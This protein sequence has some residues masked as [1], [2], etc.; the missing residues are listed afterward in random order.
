MKV[1]REMNGQ[2]FERIK[3]LSPWFPEKFRE[4]D[5]DAMVL[6]ETRGN[7]TT[8]SYTPL[9]WALNFGYGHVTVMLLEAGADPDLACRVIDI[10][11]EEATVSYPLY[12]AHDEKDARALLKAGA[13]VSSSKLR[14]RIFGCDTYAGRLVT[15]FHQS[16]LRATA[17]VWC[18]CDVLRA[19]SSWP[20]M[21]FLLTSIMMCVCP[22]KM[23]RK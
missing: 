8:V 21:A 5:I 22:N 6:L 19:T 23:K 9:G 3:E 10:P 1:S 14:Q 4:N 7:A 2:W 18:C 12:L 13:V 11:P 15:D 17:V 16:S 20:D